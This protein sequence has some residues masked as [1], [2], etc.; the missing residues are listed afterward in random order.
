MSIRAIA[1]L[2]FG[3]SFLSFA[4]L[5]PQNPANV[6]VVTRTALAIS[7]LDRGT[8]EIGPYARLTSDKA[9]Y[10]G[11]VYADKVP[12]HSL[13]ALP[14]VALGRFVRRL[15]GESTDSL[16]PAV[17]HAYSAW[18]TIGTNAP[19]SAAAVAVMFLLALAL[20]AS[21][22]GALFA[23]TCLGWATP[24]FGWSTAFFAHSVAGSLL[25]FA[26]AA[27][28][29]LFPLD[30][31]LRLSRPRQLA[32][33][34][35]LGVLL[36][37]T[38]VVET[39]AAPV[40]VLLGLLVLWR[41]WHQ[42]AS[43]KQFLAVLAALALGGIVGALPLPIYNQI[44]FGSPL[45]LGYEDTSFSGMSDGFFGL[46]W[47]DPFVLGQILLGL[48]RGLVPLAPILAFV[49]FG[50]AA[51]FRQPSLRGVALLAALAILTYLLINASYYYWNG[52]FS[53]G[54]RQIIAMLPLA[55]L[56]LAFA[57]PDGR[58][59]QAVIGAFLLASLGMSLACALAGMFAPS[60][61]I[62][63]ISGWILPNALAWANLP[64]ALPIVLVWLLLGAM[65]LRLSG[66][67]VRTGSTADRPPL[68]AQKDPS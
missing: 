39:L 43:A 13:L 50:I 9:V 35:P 52:G 68:A 11:R 1:V 19:I 53:T 23:A 67:P 47:P 20:G 66:R 6:Q 25:L 45:H 30:P 46:T 17:L 36:G 61:I 56:P 14:A 48:Y 65:L 57:W 55:C 62:D 7:I 49:P 4:L 63:E 37:Y 64:R 40:V 59:E 33:I 32:G 29:R 15:V 41:A 8:V 26:L 5:S 12:G 27:I 54:P 42:Q 10:E 24:F 51:M 16:D 2:L 28:V 31:S 18:A 44:A 3:L 58:A 60:R 38:P 22:A 34:V 21:R